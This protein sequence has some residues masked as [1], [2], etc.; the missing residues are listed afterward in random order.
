MKLD[1]R[2]FNEIILI[3]ETKDIMTDPEG[4]EVDINRAYEELIR[5]HV[6]NLVKLKY[7]D[8]QNMSQEE[9]DECYFAERDNVWGINIAMLSKKSVLYL[10]LKKWY[11]NRQEKLEEKIN[12]YQENY[13][14]GND[15]YCY[16]EVSCYGVNDE[17]IKKLIVD[18]DLLNGNGNG[19]MTKKLLSF[20]NS[21]D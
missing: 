1:E 11:D 9:F 21:M 10:A 3:D 15:N 4:V 8:W 20:I 13:F 12:N 14:F 6:E 19:N 7:E 17:E 5:P 18:K 2:I 16:F